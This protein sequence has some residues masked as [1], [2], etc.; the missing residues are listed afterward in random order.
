MV[1][2]L[3]YPERVDRLILNG[4]N[5]D[6]S[7]VKRRVQLPIE[8]GW[9]LARLSRSPEARSKAELLGLMV[10]DPNIPAEEL[11]RIRARTLVIAGTRD[12]IRTSH[13]KRIAAAIPG[14][15]L[16]LLEGDHFIAARQPRAFNKAVL[17]FLLEDGPAPEGA[18]Y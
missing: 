5:L 12:M 1:F 3:R 6:P 4:G 18:E 9:R 13:T 16:V 10:C 8:L 11:T 17:D 7:G 15:R 2:A 14:A